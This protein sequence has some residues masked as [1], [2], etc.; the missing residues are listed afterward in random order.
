MPVTRLF[1]Q[2]CLHVGLFDVQPGYVWLQPHYLF[3]DC[4]CISGSSTLAE[5]AVFP[6][7]A[8][9]GGIVYCEL[10]SN[11]SLDVLETARAI[12]SAS[13]S[14]ELGSALSATFRGQDYRTS[15][16]SLQV[17]SLNPKP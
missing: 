3:H 10:M 7:G 9:F 16:H 2:L 13:G 12:Q 8:T 4:Y 17:G 11:T 6:S 5:A 15:L 1:S 14:Q